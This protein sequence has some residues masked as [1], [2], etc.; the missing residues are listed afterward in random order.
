MNHAPFPG[1]QKGTE[2]KKKL[3]SM[4]GVAAAASLLLTAC[5]SSEPAAQGP[6]NGDKKEV[7]IGVFAGWDEGIAVS[8]LWKRILEEKG[9]E[10]T[11]TTAE[12]APVFS[13]VSTGDFDLTMDVWLPET[14]ATYLE[15]YGDKITEL[16][17]WYDDAK[18]TLAVNEDAPIDSL[19]ELAENADK[20]GNRIVGIEPGA[21]L[22]KATQKKVIPQYKLENMDFLTSSTPAMLTELKKATDAGDNIVV[23]LWRPHWAYDEFPI[24]DLKDPKKTLGTAESIH[25]IADLDFKKDYPT[26]STW[27]KNFKFPSDKLFSLEN[28]M[29]NGTGDVKDYTPVVKKWLSENKDFEAGLTK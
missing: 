10:V 12:A 9:Y 24:K 17:T 29:Y 2:M 25:S 8:N 13:G 16:G 21:G 7:K 5:G 6:E 19:D 22:T 27:L 20:F 3:A 23:T 26:V 28:A 15:Q 11:L 14:H 4:L 18:L 1:A